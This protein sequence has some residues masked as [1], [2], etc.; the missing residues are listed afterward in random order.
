MVRT[1]NLHYYDGLYCIETVIR[2][3]LKRDLNF[4]LVH[5]RPLFSPD[6]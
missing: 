1:S 4:Q 5:R 6:K 2:F 3:R